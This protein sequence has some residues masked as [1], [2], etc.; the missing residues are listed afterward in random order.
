MDC[1]GRAASAQCACYSIHILY[2][3]YALPRTLIY[4]I[5]GYIHHARCT[6]THHTCTCRHADGD[7]LRL[8]KAECT[9]LELI[10]SYMSVRMCI[11]VCMYVCVY[12]CAECNVSVLQAED[13]VI[14]AGRI[15]IA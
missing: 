3:L 11:C 12:V 9:V 13:R 5:L 10:E 8:Y 15:N 7:P 2:S 6:R 14:R 4:S 1:T